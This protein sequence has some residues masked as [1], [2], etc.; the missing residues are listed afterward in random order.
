MSVDGDGLGVG[1]IREVEVYKKG[2]SVRGSRCGC[3]FV[4]VVVICWLVVYDDLWV[5]MMLFSS[6]VKR[7]KCWIWVGDLVI[8]CCIDID[9]GY[10]VEY[11]V[12][13]LFGV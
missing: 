1:C 8:V 2:S 11:K 13:I 5:L 10:V 12:C 9:S 3:L 6:F 7:S 4:I